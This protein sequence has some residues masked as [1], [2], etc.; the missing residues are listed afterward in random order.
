[1]LVDGVA[2]SDSYKPIDS[3]HNV[4]DEVDAVCLVGDS[5][6]NCCVAN[7]V[8]VEIAEV[9]TTCYYHYDN[10]VMIRDDSRIAICVVRTLGH[11][12]YFQFTSQFFLFSK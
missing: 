10:P 6:Y 7:E 9:M 12:T 5:L 11:L 3:C 4:Q 1:M 2:V 8:T